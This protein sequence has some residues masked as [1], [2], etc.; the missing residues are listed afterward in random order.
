MAR[1]QFSL[2]RQ[3]SRQSTNKHRRRQEAVQ[4]PWGTGSV[5]APGGV[6]SP[7]SF[8][9]TRLGFSSEGRDSS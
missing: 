6:E 5:P 8:G 7:P 2:T 3:L 1:G 9:N 4:E